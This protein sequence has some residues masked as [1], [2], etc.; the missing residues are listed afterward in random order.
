MA[1]TAVEVIMKKSSIS[2]KAPSTTDIDFGEIAINTADGKIFIKKGDLTGDII[3]EVG[4]TTITG[5]V[6]GSGNGTI[7]ATLANSGVV[8]NTYTKVT[9]N[10]KGIVT[11][12][13]TLVAADIPSLDWSK[14]TSGKPTTLAGYGIK[15]APVVNP[16]NPKD[17]DI[18]IANGLI[19]MYGAGYWRQ[20]SN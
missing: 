17:G 13:S 11:S 19:Y 6:T 1:N 3:I 5:D 4:K 18:K 8:P 7:T 14:I 12:G 2:G 20:V 10:S 15:D 9:V 16:A